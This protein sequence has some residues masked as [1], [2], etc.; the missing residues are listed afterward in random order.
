MSDLL[1]E[2]Q[3]VLARVLPL[4][5]QEPLTFP[6]E[7]DMVSARHGEAADQ[8]RAHSSEELKRRIRD[9]LTGADFGDNDFLSIEEHAE[10]LI[11]Q[12]TDLY[13]LARMY[14][15]WCPFW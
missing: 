5:V 10:R 1:R 8:P 13:N 4:F 3:R 9:K 15:G 11:E 2:N 7:V 6:E 12:A 14:S